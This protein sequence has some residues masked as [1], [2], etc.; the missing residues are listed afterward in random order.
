MSL[1]LPLTEIVSS[2]RLPYRN[3]KSAGSVR[4]LL[5]HHQA[6]NSLL[7]PPPGLDSYLLAGLIVQGT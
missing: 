4:L 5:L 3:L 7:L 2:S 1:M 6:A